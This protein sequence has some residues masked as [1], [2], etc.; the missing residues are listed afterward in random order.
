MVMARPRLQVA[1]RR[2]V[3][4]LPL[5]GE[6]STMR[7]LCVVLAFARVTARCARDLSMES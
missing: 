3:P 4:D 5:E 6:F 1:R 7:E 2:E